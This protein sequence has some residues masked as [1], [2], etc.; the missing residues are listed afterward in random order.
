MTFVSVHVDVLQMCSYVVY[1]SHLDTVQNN[2]ACGH[3]TAFTSYIITLPSLPTLSVWSP[4]Y[5]RRRSSGSF[6]LLRDRNE[7]KRLSK[8][9]RSVSTFQSQQKQPVSRLPSVQIKQGAQPE[10]LTKTILELLFC[11]IFWKMR[12]TYVA[13]VVFGFYL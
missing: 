6:H 12:N 1:I 13:S 11:Y 4:P 2:K 9:E 8:N 10:N 5:S 7:M 3:Y